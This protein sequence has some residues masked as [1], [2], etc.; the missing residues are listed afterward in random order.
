LPSHSSVA[1]RRCPLGMIAT[2]PPASQDGTPVALSRM[3]PKRCPS[4]LPSQHVNN[5]TTC[6]SRWDHCCS[7]P[8]ITQALALNATPLS[9]SNFTACLS[10][11]GLCC[12]LIH[13]SLA[14]LHN[15]DLDTPLPSLSSYTL[16][17]SLSY[18]YS[19]LNTA[20]SCRDLNLPSCW[21]PHALPSPSGFR[22]P[23][24]RCHCTICRLQASSP[25]ALHGPRSL[26]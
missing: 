6:L 20:T 5:F 22:L 26:P 16:F 7:L 12:P 25:L 21:R 13:V 15:A 24:S 14:L 10:G 17:I 2:S 23:S 18:I 8:H 3:T 11:R 19:C 4:T 9:A 1:F